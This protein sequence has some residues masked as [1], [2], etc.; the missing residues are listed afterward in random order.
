MKSSQRR[1]RVRTPRVL[2][3]YY[4]MT[5]NSRRIAGE[6]QQALGA[7][8]EEIREP[9]PRHGFIG[10]LRAMWDATT[11]RLPPLSPIHHDPGELDLLVLGGPIWSGRIASPVRAYMT[12]FGHRAPRVAFFCTEGGRGSDMAFA[13]LESMCRR[14]RVGSLVIDAAHLAADAHGRA[15]SDFVREVRRALPA[16]PSRAE[17]EMAQDS[18][19]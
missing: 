14:E 18:A 2:V 10:V 6:L 15:V 5:G 19:A 11:R 8:I 7:E 13:E 12:L 3:A 1:N 4:S 16:T 9:R 17:Q